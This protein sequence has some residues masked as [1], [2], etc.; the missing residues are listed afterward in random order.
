MQH[1][2]QPRRLLLDE[3][4]RRGDT[5]RLLEKT[6]RNKECNFNTI[7]AEEVLISKYMTAIT[8]KKLRDKLIEK[9]DRTSKTKHI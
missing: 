2:P 7:T 5:R 8:D 1:L 3:T 4:D 9:N 6:N